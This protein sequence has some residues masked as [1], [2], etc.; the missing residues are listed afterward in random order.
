[1]DQESS[2]RGGAQLEEADRVQH[3]PTS[4]GASEPFTSD[5][6]PWR[7]GKCKWYNVVRGYGYIVPDDGGEDVFAHQTA[8]IREGFRSL[9]AGEVVEFL[10]APTERGMQ[11]S[12]VRGP[13]GFQCQ[14]S[15]HRPRS[16]QQIQ[17]SRCFNCG[18]V[19][20]HYAA[21][22]PLG[23]LDKS[24]YFCRSPQHLAADCPA[25]AKVAGAADPKAK[26]VASELVLLRSPSQPV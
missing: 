5:E 12:K 21:E 4:S 7:T 13:T 2:R 25:R 14:G 6:R 9:G 11:A 20:G 18:S 24:C 26:A 10:S 1:M 3:E 15:D 8:I 22:C 23:P 19:C 16:R 17:A